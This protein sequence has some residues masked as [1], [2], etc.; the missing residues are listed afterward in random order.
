MNKQLQLAEAQQ[1]KHELLMGKKVVSIT[2]DGKKVDFQ[3]TNIAELDRYIQQLSGHRRAMR[4][5][6]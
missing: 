1:A 2:R 3:Q 5:S 4:F 6:L